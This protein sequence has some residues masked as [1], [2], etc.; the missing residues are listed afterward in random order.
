MTF[1]ARRWLSLSTSIGR[2]P[3]PITPML[4]LT[5]SKNQNERGDLKLETF[6][7]TLSK[8]LNCDDLCQ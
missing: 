3:E 2:D 8:C 7:V 5:N 4:K 1:T 6:E